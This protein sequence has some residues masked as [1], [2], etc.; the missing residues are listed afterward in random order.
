M[1][2]ISPE[3]HEALE[4]KV[5]EF[6]QSQ[7]Q[8]RDF[9]FEG[10]VT[11]LSRSLKRISRK[12]H[13]KKK[14]AFSEDELYVASLN[15]LWN[16]SVRFT[17]ENGHKFM[18]FAKKRIIGSILDYIR[19][20]DPLTRGERKR[21]SIFKSKRYSFVKAN[22]RSPTLGELCDLTEFTSN[23]ITEICRYLSLIH[24]L[25]IGARSYFGEISAGHIEETPLSD[26]DMGYWWEE[27]PQGTEPDPIDST[28]AS[29]LESNLEWFVRRSFILARSDTG[30]YINERAL[31]S[32]ERETMIVMGYLGGKNLR[33]IG[34]SLDVSE[35]R[36]CQILKELRTSP[37]FREKLLLEPGEYVVGKQYHKPSA[38]TAKSVEDPQI[39]DAA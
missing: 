23:E 7:G 38:N 11:V 29:D 26:G 20:C 31:Q 19:E 21:V 22:G 25:S 10:I 12:I 17:P 33:E 1:G 32:I 37:H 18:T 2:K 6:Q 28:I 3:F 36:A 4:K 14:K 34:V 5:L 35:S 24:A 15:G 16:V 8:K 9:E 13:L 27:M 30:S 39:R